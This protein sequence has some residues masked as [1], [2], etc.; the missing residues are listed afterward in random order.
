[1]K[2]ADLYI[3]VST[4]E[5]ADKGYSQRDQEERLRKYCELNSMQVRKV[6]IEDHSAKTF[7]RPAWKKFLAELRVRRGH[8]DLVLFTKWDRFSRN[9]GDAYQMISTLRKLGVEPQ[10]VEQPLDLAIPE[11][12]MMLAFYLA[13]PEV[14]NDRRA[15]NVF[16][17]MR[18]AKK[19]GRV[20]GRAP[21]GYKNKI[22]EDGKKIIAIKE[23]EAAIMRWVF[24]EL[25]KGQINTQQIWRLA[26]AK[27]LNSYKNSFWIALR[28]PIYY[29]KVFIAKYKDEESHLAQGQHEPLISE[30]L[31]YDVQ[32]VLDGRKKIKRTTMTV[33]PQLPLR[34][35]LICPECGKTLTGSASKGRYKYYHYYHCTLGCPFREKAPVVNERIAEEIQKYTRPL[36]F[37]ELYKQAIT[38]VF[39]NKTKFQRSDINQ[40]KTELEEIDK[41]LTRARNLLIAGDLD[42][43]DYRKIKMESEEKI[44]RLEAMLTVKNTT[45]TNVEP[46]LNKA[47]S[48]IS[49]LATL[50]NEGT[51][52]N[53]RKIIGSIFPEK[54]TFENN[55]VRTTRINEGL[56]LMLL[57]YKGLDG[58][59]KGTNQQ[60]SDLSQYV[61]AEGFEPSTA[62]LEGRCSIQLSYASIILFVGVAGFEPAASCSQSRR[63]NRATLHPEYNLNL[64]MKI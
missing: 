2:I 33:D 55:Q 24:E 31:F 56:R 42:P 39:K 23:D 45:I 62:C 34:G 11:N 64:F 6:I 22:N 21:L 13:A 25:A 58:K 32:D 17:G 29:G 40:L 60:K 7:N 1:M 36:P 57:F 5:Q 4:D 43:D 63:D 52:E 10:A 20:M 46:L 9:A 28:N 3:R 26:N 12:K 15:L 44:N 30:S 35:Y 54:L 61:N 50:Y 27:G 14:E 41:R 8:S 48:Q 59:K 18:R 51:T 16:N 49:Q 19:E 47:I 37:L 53:K 38:S